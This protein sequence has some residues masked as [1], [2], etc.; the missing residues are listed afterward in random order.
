MAPPNLRVYAIGDVHGRVD[1]LEQAFAK[2]DVD[3]KKKPPAQS[4][5]VLLG[6]YIDRGP[7]SRQVI[8]LL[9]GRKRHRP[10]MCLKGNHEVYIQE[11]LQNPSILD[12]WQQYGALETLMSYGLKP[13]LTSDMNEKE[14]LA[15]ALSNALPQSH[16]LFFA[17]LGASISCGD[18]LFVH[19]GVRPGV[20]LDEQ[21]EEDML[22]IREDFLLC[23]D[24]FGKVIVHGHTPV[25]EPDF[26][27]N[28]I[29]I[30]TGA[31]ATGKLTCLVI[32]RDQVLVLEDT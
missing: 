10:M 32:E 28:R 20:P 24:D 14:E 4:L 19:A 9:I 1:L 6:D 5:E 17:S 25:R 27:P 16:R 23:E 21:R 22:W 18:Y 11:F 30:D 31:Y 13:K 26:Q 3:L 2:I 29:N 8:D 7:N 12:D 15:G